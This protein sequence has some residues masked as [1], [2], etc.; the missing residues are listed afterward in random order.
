ML[1][2]E[3][4]RLGP[5]L[6]ASLVAVA[7]ARWWLNEER[8]A[9]A[10]VAGVL[11]MA[12]AFVMAVNACTFVLNDDEVFYLADSHAQWKG[13]TSGYLPLRYLL[14][15]PLVALLDRPSSMVMSARLAMIAMAAGCGLAAWRMARA[16]GAAS[17]VAA[18]A[19]AVATLWLATAVQ[20]VFLRPEYIAAALVSAGLVLLV[21]PPERLSPRAA[22]AAGF[23]LLALAGGVSPRQGL[24]LPFAWAVLA[25]HPRGLSR[26]GALGWSLLG[27]A[28]GALPTVAYVLAFDEPRAIWYWSVVVPAEYG[29]LSS[30][31][32]AKFPLALFAVA[33][34]GLTAMAL[35]SRSDRRPGESMVAA[36][37]IGGSLLPML[38]PHWLAYAHGPWVVTSIVLGAVFWCR[39]APRASAW[40]WRAALA[41]FALSAVAPLLHPAGPRRP[42]PSGLRSQLG[43]IDWLG[44]VSSGRA[45]ACVS[46]YHP[47]RAR[48]AW[49]WWNAWWYC[50]R[51]DPA[52]LRSMP[53]SDVGLP[54]DGEAAV[55]QWDAWPQNSGQANVIAWAL[56]RDLLARADAEQM[57]AHLARDYRLVRWRQA[58]PGPYGGGAFLIHRALGVDDRVEV[59]D[60][61]HVLGAAP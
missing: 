32:A 50:Y 48:N 55:I 13:E 23:V 9:R 29:P 46:P 2:F 17:T 12:A 31:P 40:G 56:S 59:L 57:V 25:W 39:A 42:A 35:V 22:I 33:A 14:L 18:S 6:A 37:W 52:L 24:L 61:R 1:T 3:V 16:L 47:I 4:S 28:L 10:W 19:G 44:E 41:V 15:R 26:T 34:G 43:L 36:L 38:M 54:R 27:V 21:A 5:A 45:V 8:K 51:R 7:L 58:L 53:G 49:R 30:E 11:W 60:D 20:M